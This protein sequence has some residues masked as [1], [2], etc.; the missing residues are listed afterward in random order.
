MSQESG[1]LVK[2]AA[3]PLTTSRAEVTLGL[4]GVGAADVL[5][6]TLKEERKCYKGG[7]WLG[8]EVRMGSD[9]A[10]QLRR[11]GPSEDTS[12]EFLNGTWFL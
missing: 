2:A 7:L 10:P 8:A 1:S 4:P 3:D 5:E 9:S 11:A 6:K 12:L